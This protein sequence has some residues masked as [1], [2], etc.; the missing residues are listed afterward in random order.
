MC[1][2]Y[3]GGDPRA[4]CGP[5]PPGECSV[6]RT[7]PKA[8]SRT[9]L[10]SEPPGVSAVP[11]L[12]AGISRCGCRERP[13]TGPGAG[14]APGRRLADWLLSPDEAPTILPTAMFLAD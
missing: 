1:S 11:R 7:L 12:F 5:F 8:A 3:E 6:A 10:A 9:Q 4:G 13:S 14:A 2:S